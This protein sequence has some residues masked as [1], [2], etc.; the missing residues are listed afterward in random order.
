MADRYDSDY[1]SRYGNRDHFSKTSRPLPTEP[2]FTAFVGNLPDGVV[3]SDIDEIFKAVEVSIKSVRLVRDKETDKFKGYCYVEL[4]DLESLK[5]SLELDSCLVQGMPLRVDVAEGRR[6]DRGGGF[7]NRQR[8]GG[9]FERGGGRGG[10]RDGGRFGDRGGRPGG[11]RGMGGG[12]MGGYRGGGMGGGGFTDR[13]REFD[14]S[15]RGGPGGPGG[16][17]AP[18]APGSYASRGGPPRDRGPATEEFREPTSE[19]ASHRPRLKLLPRTVAAPVADIADTSNRSAIFG[20]AKP[21]D[22]KAYEKAR[23]TSEGDSQSAEGDED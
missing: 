10:P 6:S 3:Q 5:K 9:G 11:D 22:E 8:G 21:R 23:K 16:P 19:E 13:D 2:P 18:G 14:R 4:Y 12:G 20:G 15:R 17:G 1:G 7:T